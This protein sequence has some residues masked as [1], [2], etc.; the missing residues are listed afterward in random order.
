MSGSQYN[1]NKN[2]KSNTDKNKGKNNCD[3]GNNKVSSSLTEK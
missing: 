2:E 1:K 3:K